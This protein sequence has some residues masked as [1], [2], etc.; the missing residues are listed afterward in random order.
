VG[1]QFVLI[2]HEMGE[3]ETYLYFKR[4]NVDV[5]DVSVIWVQRTASGGIGTTSA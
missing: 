2:W 4:L 5:S 3:W 1:I